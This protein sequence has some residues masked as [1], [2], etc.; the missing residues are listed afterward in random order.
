MFTF[1]RTGKAILSWILCIAMVIGL[2]PEMAFNASAASPKVTITG[3]HM[4]DSSWTVDP[5]TYE[6]RSLDRQPSI[7]MEWTATGLEAL[8]GNS[9]YNAYIYVTPYTLKKTK[10]MLEENAR[11]NGT[12]TEYSLRELEQSDTAN[13]WM[14]GAFGDSISNTGGSYNGMLKDFFTTKKDACLNMGDT[15][16]YQLVIDKVVSTNQGYDVTTVVT[17]SLTQTVTDYFVGMPYMTAD[18]DYG[19]RA[20]TAELAY[21]WSDAL[22]LTPRSGY[23]YEAD[24]FIWPE[25]AVTMGDP[26]SA[27]FG[28]IN[29]LSWSEEMGDR[30][31]MPNGAW[32]SG[33]MY[34]YDNTGEMPDPITLA[35]GSWVVMGLEIYE[36]NSTTYESTVYRRAPAVEFQISSGG[37]TVTQPSLSSP[38]L[39]IN[40][41]VANDA[42]VTKIDGDF[43]FDSLKNGTT[44]LTSGTDYTVSGN[45]VTIKKDYLSSLGAGTH[46][47]TFHYTGEVN[48]TS[49]IDPTLT[50]TITQLCNPTVTVTGY[51]DA[52]IT[53]DTTIVWKNRYGYTVS[54][55]FPVQ[56]G[57]TYTYT[58][59]PGDALKIDGVQY[60]KEATGSVTITEDNQAVNIALGQTGTV[61]AVPRSNGTEITGGFTVCWYTK[62]YYNMYESSTVSK[63]AAGGGYDDDYY[64]IGYGKTSPKVNT[65]TVLYCDVIMSGDNVD[66][67]GNIEKAQ[68]TVGFGNSPQD[69]AA[70]VKNNITLN[71]TGEEGLTLTSDDYTIT[72][73]KKE[74]EGYKKVSTGAMLSN[75][76]SLVGQSFYYEITPR[77]YYSYTKR[78]TVY[79]WLNFCGVALSEATKVTVAEEAQ[80]INVE[81]KKIGLVTLSGT[82][83]NLAQVG[84]DNL[85]FTV[86]QDPF[87]GYLNA[88]S[89]YSYGS[90][91]SDLTKSLTVNNDGTFSMQVWNF[92]VTMKIVEKTGNFRNCYKTISAADIEKPVTV[93]L[94]AEDLPT[95]IPLEITQ[96]YPNWRSDTGSSTQELYIGSWSSNEGIFNDMVFTLTNTTKGAVI[97]PSLYNVTISEVQFTGDVSAVIEMGDTLTLSYTIDEIAGEVAQTSDSVKVLKDYYLTN[98]DWEDRC[99]N[100]SYKD[101]GNIYYT[102]PDGYTRHLIGAYDA[103]GELVAS[104]NDSYSGWVNSVPAG[105]YT[106]VNV[107]ANNWFSLPATLE[108]FDVLSESEYLKKTGVVVQN[109]VCTTVNFGASPDVGSHPAFTENSKFGEDTVKT[110]AE[111]WALVKLAYEVDPAMAKANPGA[112]YAITVNV[113]T[114]YAGTDTTPIVP[115]Y[116]ARGYGDVRRD[117]Y[118]SLYCDNKLTE[119]TVKINQRDA[120]HLQA[121]K[122]FTLYTDKTS[123]VIWF[124]LQ[125]A[126]GGDFNITAQGARVNEYSQEVNVQSFGN[127]TLSVSAA[128]GE[129]NINSDYLLISGKKAYKNNAWLYTTPDCESELYMDG[130]KIARYRTSGTGIAYFTFQI[131]DSK[132]GSEN[133]STFLAKDPAWTA[134]GEHELYAITTKNGT[135]TRSATT[136]ITAVTEQNFTPAVIRCVDVKL[137]SDNEN[138]PFSG[139]I[140]NLFDTYS[141]YSG[142]RYISNYYYS[143]NDQGNV[144]TYEFTA[145]VPDGNNVDSMY[146][147]VTGQDGEE[148]ITE[149]KRDGDTN[150]FVGSVSGEKFLFTNWSV[151]VKSKADITIKGDYIG[152]EDAFLAAYG[153]VK[154]NDPETGAEMT[155]TQ[156]YQQEYDKLANTYLEEQEKLVQDRQEVLDIFFEGLKQFDDMLEG[157]NFDYSTYD[158]SEESMKALQEHFGIYETTYLDDDGNPTV[159][160]SLWKP[161]QKTNKVVWPNGQIIW[162]DETFLPYAETIGS[163]GR[164][165]RAT[166][167]EEVDPTTRHLI[168]VQYAVAFPLE[169]VEGDKGYVY[170]QGIDCGEVSIDVPAM[171]IAA[172]IY[173]YNAGDV[174]QKLGKGGDG[175]KWPTMSKAGIKSLGNSGNILNAIHKKV[176]GTQT[177]YAKSLAG[178]RAGLNVGYQWEHRQQTKAEINAQTAID[179]LIDSGK[180][181]GDDLDLAKDIK[182]DIDA[183]CKAT[184]TA[185][186]ATAM[187]IMMEKINIVAESLNEVK[188]T[189]NDLIEN[190]FKD[191]LKQQ[192]ID[193][194]RE[195]IEDKT[196]ITIPTDLKEACCALLEVYASGKLSEAEKR[197]IE[198]YLKTQALAKKTHTRIPNDASGSGGSGV[199]GRSSGGSVRATHDPEGI[200]YEAVLSNP[201]EGATATLYERDLTTG[202]VSQWNAEEYGQLN[203]QVT[204]N[205]GWYQWFVPEGEWQVRV[206]AP[207]GSGLSDNTS[208]DNAAANLDDGSTA[209]WLPVM[210]VQLGIN[211]PLVSKNAP[212]VKSV[213][214]AEDGIEIEFSLYMDVKTLTDDVFTLTL[215]GENVPFTVSFVNLDNDPLDPNNKSYASKVKLIPAAGLKAGKTYAVAVRSGVKAYNDKLLAADYS[216]EV[217]TEGPQID[218]TEIT[219]GADKD[220]KTINDALTEINK[221][222]KAKTA[223]NAYVF[224]VDEGNI[225]AKAVTLPKSDIKFA[226]TGGK[227]T[228]KSPTITANS[229]LSLWCAIE[230]EKAGKTI[231]VKAAADKKVVVYGL[232]IETGT[233]TLSGTK[234]SEFVFDTGSGLRVLSF[235]GANAQIAK[236]TTIEL[237]NGKFIPVTLTGD[238]VINAREASTVTI[239]DAVNADIILNQY[240]GKKASVLLPKLT[241]GTVG[242]VKLT[243]NDPDGELADISGMTVINLSKNDTVAGIDQKITIVNTIGEG[244]DALPLS[245]VQYKKEVRA[246]YL[247]ALTLTIDGK[248]SNYSSFEKIG[249][250]MAANAK[251]NAQSVYTIKLNVATSLTKLTLPSKAASLT[252]DGNGKALTFIGVTSLAP[253]YAFTL[254]DITIKALTKA[255]ADSAFTVN[256]T[257]GNTVI[258]ALGFDGKTLSIKGG[259]K[260]TL[261]LGACAPV[262]TLSGFETIMLEAP[263]TVTKTLTATN[264]TLNAGADLTIGTGA[265][266]TVKKILRGTD[267]AKITLADSYKSLTLSGSVEGEKIKLVSAKTLEDKVIIKSKLDLSGKFDISGI[268]PVPQGDYTYDLITKSGSVYLKAYTIDLNGKKYAFWEDAINAINSGTTDYELSLLADVNIG[269]ALK[270]PAKGK[271]ASL[272]IIGNGNKLTFT[273][274]SASLKGTTTF[275][276]IKLNAV[277]VVK[278]TETPVAYKFTVPKGSTLTFENV[279]SFAPVTATG[280]TVNGEVTLINAA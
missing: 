86:T 141:D 60:Y 104:T 134:A 38:S 120:W 179:G 175:F 8:S 119:S 217:R 131:T 43:T 17:T 115:R 32:N 194:A 54:N 264:I 62:G 186:F 33:Y 222:I 243:V 182:N 145:T 227:F 272:T 254:K 96:I 133:I 270:V 240:L 170:M 101:Y 84:K 24:F 76:V 40:A 144:F 61:T 69:I 149:L 203:P 100:L 63:D 202:D 21:S 198:L 1:K 180:L 110:T 93:T 242:T 201:V 268:A 27:Q 176:V 4:T 223:D 169:G 229:D 183:I 70:G 279:T 195:A 123:G 213:T 273:G 187:K 258:N 197:A 260:N 122:G 184:D 14:A 209:G 97:D 277:K 241:I 66:K 48:G 16:T 199:T 112:Q 46:T 226:I 225:E 23:F 130:V 3:F 210:P 218:G 235:S 67:Y 89:Y 106:V 142:V 248:D 205:A 114:G 153:N 234:T 73:Y 68:V 125:A 6:F 206:T 167:T 190:G 109:G 259:S 127:M 74:G 121:L 82:V 57:T 103:N 81:L 99:F 83:T 265:A 256:S 12:T 200:I 177:Q 10:S 18:M 266:A 211:I 151:S 157:K 150:K 87:A 189:V 36:Y 124:Y 280:G 220:F 15:V 215:G 105:T 113:G 25:A 50:I 5:D 191:Y 261:T 193:E 232:A 173:P 78:E 204:T 148:Y 30:V 90:K 231:T 156:Y 29:T 271:F 147:T 163:D 188:D 7:S 135:E 208:A 79:N 129:L 274:T 269:G 71:V 143:L 219:I 117:K 146:I 138:D 111:E 255:G 98:L 257:T 77:D 262:D 221:L 253:K 94:S 88:S 56:S 233:L 236:G 155:V 249:D 168:C 126:K 20:Y 244:E 72:W 53:A 31:L 118:I 238:G 196:G 9:E 41:P 166:T 65:G 228:M 85:T 247:D 160:D 116:E 252:I 95:S 178:I 172:Q 64:S 37:P 44:T 246:E 108:G 174:L 128:S 42:S 154:I 214:A 49:P 34:W 26:Y 51:D 224:V 185:D 181:S 267:G 35:E 212:T 250:A 132:V 102:S 92:G 164:I 91:W 19:M 171:S 55:P 11:L 22:T 45:T 278:G 251:T 237:D 207:E 276:N 136:T 165:I 137:I 139:R 245:A 59:T 80:T 2:L 263:L 275:S 239:T 192:A 230:P 158:G 159:P 107:K 58:A 152:D 39:S 162:T 161:V 75:L 13:M 47:I 28:Y 52:D 140:S 216:S